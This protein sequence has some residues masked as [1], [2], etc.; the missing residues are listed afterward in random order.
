MQK[1]KRGY[2]LL[3]HFIYPK[4]L[5]E[6]KIIINNMAGRI[7]LP[8]LYE[9]KVHILLVYPFPQNKTKDYSHCHNLSVHKTVERKKNSEGEL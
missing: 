3:L 5:I 2:G 6:G 8:V 9:N 7:D 4:G 1:S